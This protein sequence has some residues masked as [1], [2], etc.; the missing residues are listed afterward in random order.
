MS[1]MDILDVAETEIGTIYLGRRQVEGLAGDVYEILIADEVLMTSLA[2]V[3]ERALSHRALAQH[4]SKGPL[5]VLVGGLGLGYTAQAALS[6]ARVGEVLVA[7][8]MPFI[9][10]WM[11]RGK[12]PLSEEFADNKRLRIE[13]SDCY[14][15]L[16]G[17]ASETFDLILV[18]IDHAPDA[19]LSPAS[20]PFYTVSGQQQVAAHL[21]PG[22]T[23]GIWS[24]DDNEEFLAVLGEVYAE[25]HCEAVCWQDPEFPEA[26]YENS[27][28]FARKR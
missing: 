24:I 18:D 5:R 14:E 1:A 11:Q 8:K 12:L 9:I 22:G 27:L 20:A 28:F 15:R 6:D 23:L 13:E 4:T 10:H 21:S 3:S 7:E 25:S 19:P 17:P 16:L 2:P 26:D